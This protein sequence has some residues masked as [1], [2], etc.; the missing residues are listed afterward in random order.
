[1]G[2]ALAGTAFADAGGGNPSDGTDN[3]IGNGG[4]N[5]G[6]G[7]NNGNNGGGNGNNTPAA[8]EPGQLLMAATGVMLVG[9]YI[10]WRRNRV[11]QAV[12]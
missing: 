8:P 12:R 7:N 1:M 3:G 4:V 6:G 2:L 5:N 10:V 11:A 9:G